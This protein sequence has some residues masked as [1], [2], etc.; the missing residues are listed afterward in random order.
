MSLDVLLSS[1]RLRS[2]HI[3]LRTYAYIRSLFFERIVLFTV[4]KYS[5]LAGI[6]SG[7]CVFFTL[8]DTV[9]LFS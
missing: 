3:I 8:S 4:S 1:P 9:V 5:L 2:V 6:E 7:T